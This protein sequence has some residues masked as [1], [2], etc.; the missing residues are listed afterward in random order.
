MMIGY[1]FICTCPNSY[2]ELANNMVRMVYSKKNPQTSRR[3]LRVWFY[4]V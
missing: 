2:H 3:Y 4:V 1:S